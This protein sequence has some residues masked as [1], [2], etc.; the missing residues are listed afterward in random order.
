MIRATCQHCGCY[1]A[2]TESIL[3]DRN[4][5]MQIPDYLSSAPTVNPPG[6]ISV[7]TV[8]ESVLEEAQRLTHGPRQ[9]AYGHPLDD[10]TRT[11]GLINAML[12]HKLKEPLTAHDAAL[13]QVC[14]K[15]SREIHR[16][17]RDNAVDGAGY[18]WVAHACLE[19]A[20]RRATQTK[21]EETK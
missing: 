18:F 9:D 20:E 15:L 10:Y 4:C 5:P 17:K 21:T 11:A 1:A 8:G 19:E 7:G 16:P 13:I 2:T 12:S 14:V 3:H 6:T